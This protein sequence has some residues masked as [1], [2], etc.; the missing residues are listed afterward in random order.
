MRIKG[1]DPSKKKTMKKERLEVE[2]LLV[3]R[4]KI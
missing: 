3:G 1:E 4:W 2:M